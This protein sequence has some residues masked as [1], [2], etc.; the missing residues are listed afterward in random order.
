MY[1][2]YGIGISVRRVVVPYNTGQNRVNLF[3]IWN[4]FVIAKSDLADSRPWLYRL[5]F[6]YS[7]SNKTSG[8]LVFHR[9]NYRVHT[10][11]VRRTIYFIDLFFFSLAIL[12][13]V[14]YILDDEYNLY[15]HCSNNDGPRE[16][17]IINKSA[18]SEKNDWF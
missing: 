15:K 5:S 14:H 16:E 4:S 3:Y 13:F 1:K 18:R 2:L 11:T 10:T 6:E 17:K 9:V 8:G 12:F 7:T